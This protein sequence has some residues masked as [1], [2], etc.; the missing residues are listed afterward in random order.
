[1]ALLPQSN[2]LQLLPKETKTSTGVSTC[3]QKHTDLRA[4]DFKHSSDL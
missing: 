1:M 4:Q 2:D 3:Q